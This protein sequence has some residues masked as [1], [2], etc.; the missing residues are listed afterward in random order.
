MKNIIFRKEFNLYT[1]IK[2]REYSH[3]YEKFEQRE[4]STRD[5]V[6]QPFFSIEKSF[7]DE[8]TFVENFANPMYTVHRE[9][10][11][12]SVETNGDKVSIKYFFGYKKRNVGQKWFKL[13]KNVDFLTVNIETGDVYSGF[14]H[15]YQ[16][17]KKFTKNIR[18]NYFFHNPLSTMTSKIKNNLTHLHENSSKIVNEVVSI[19]MKNIPCPEN[20]LCPDVK[21]LRFY[22]D[23]KSYKYPDNFWLYSEFFISPTF[24]KELKKNQKNIVQAFMYS[25]ELKGKKLRKFLHECSNLNLQTYLSAKSLFG[26]DR[27]N[28]DGD[29]IKNILESTSTPIDNMNISFSPNELSKVYLTFKNVILNKTID[30]WTFNDHLLMYQRLKFYGE[31]DLKW[32]TDGSDYKKFTDEH[33]DFTDKL[34]HYKKG[35]YTRKYPDYLVKAIEKELDG[36]LPIVLKTSK[37]YNEE[38]MYQS[39]CVKGYIGRP[40][41]LI[42]S[43]RKGEIDSLER[44]TLE[45]KVYRLKNSDIIQIDR[46]QSL[47]KFNQRLEDYWTDVLLKLDKI[48]VSSCSDKKFKTVKINKLCSNGLFLESDSKFTDQGFLVWDTDNKHL[49][50]Q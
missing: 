42:I 10:H 25:F 29:F 34:A 35:I 5:Y 6:K 50:E 39:N 27:L 48:V 4:N 40:S 13:V 18:R 44:A 24:K 15:N 2:Y 33:L 36:Y 30:M 31:T 46:V 47:G 28:Q 43:L 17:K 3:I 38:S 12:V 49:L 1:T 45:Y 19:F 37:D 20:A 32:T 11:T 41:S 21:L 7:N 8:K 26:D 9:Y 14:L 16:K 22:L 23:K